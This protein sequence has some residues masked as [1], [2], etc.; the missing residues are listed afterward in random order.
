MGYTHY[1]NLPKKGKNY[2]QE[3]IYVSMDIKRILEIVPKD[4]V[5]RGGDG[6]GEPEF[7]KELICFNGDGSKGLDH[8]TFYFDGVTDFSFCKTARKPYDIVVCLVLLCLYNNI[9]GF[10]FSSDGDREEWEPIIQMYENLIGEVKQ[11]IKDKIY[12]VVE[13]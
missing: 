3:M 1:W 6:T 12:G 9:T 13:N 8:E 11:E 2:E 7:Y 10:D 5:L 4:I